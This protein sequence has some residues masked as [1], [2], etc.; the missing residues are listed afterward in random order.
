MLKLYQIEWC[1][2]CHR[3]RQVMTELGLTYMT[4]NVPAD[5]D[6]RAEVMAVSGQ[7]GVPVLQDDDTVLTDSDEI[8]T[9]LRDTYPA[10]DDAKRHAAMGAWRTSRAL[11]LA[12]PAAL[13]RLKHVLEEKG[14]S[15]VVEISGQKN[16]ELLPEDYVLLEV[17]VPAAAAKSVEI[18]PLAPVAVLLPVAVMPAAAGG[19]VVATTDPVGQ[20][21]LYGEP[22]L[23]KVQA[24]VKKRL[25]EVLSAL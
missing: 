9:Y 20:V 11:P 14:F 7:L 24:M 19:S 18:D 3:V 8:L 1:G 15:I 23:N 25:A 22:A 12:P 10:P 6:E 13:A 4:V 17:A 2:Y 21:W 16:G 5:R